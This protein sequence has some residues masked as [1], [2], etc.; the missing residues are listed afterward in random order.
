MYIMKFWIRSFVSTKY[1]V[2]KI[3]RKTLHATESINMLGGT[4]FPPQMSDRPVSS[5]DVVCLT[6]RP[7]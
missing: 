4:T 6:D 2:D 1:S 7:L 5:N 3:A